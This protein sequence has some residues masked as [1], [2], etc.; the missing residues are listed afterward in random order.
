MLIVKLVL[1]KK[2][3]VKVFSRHILINPPFLFSH[4]LRRVGFF[5]IVK[6]SEICRFAEV[7]SYLLYFLEDLDEFIYVFSGCVDMETDAASTRLIEVL[8]EWKST[9]STT[10]DSDLMIGTVLS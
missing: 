4:S 1:L 5:C 6:N 3:L 7:D 9:V 2:V 8:S 10:A